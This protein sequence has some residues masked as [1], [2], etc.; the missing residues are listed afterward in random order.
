MNKHPS[1]LPVSAWKYGTS[2]SKG[3]E[4]E[5]QKNDVTCSG[6]A[7]LSWLPA[8]EQLS[9]QLPGATLTS[10]AE[11]LLKR[12][13]SL[14]KGTDSL[15]GKSS[16]EHKDYGKSNVHGS[17]TY[18]SFLLLPKDKIKSSSSIDQRDVAALQH[19]YLC[20]DCSHR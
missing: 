15:W 4:M 19:R 20:W 13:G 14:F 7:S 5:L 1:W 8:V 17:F 10:D 16:S 9:L 12:T 2:D 18:I 11:C 6:L 3:F